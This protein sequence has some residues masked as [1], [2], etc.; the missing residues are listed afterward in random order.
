[1]LSLLLFCG[2]THLAI[3]TMKFMELCKYG[4]KRFTDTDWSVLVLSSVAVMSWLCSL[5][6]R[7]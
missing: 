6:A 7:S 3:S 1:M 2:A 5:A 4:P